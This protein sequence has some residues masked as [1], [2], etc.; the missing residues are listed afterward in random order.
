M[1]KKERVILVKGDQSKWYEQAIF[2]VNQ[3]TPQDQMPLDFVSEAEKIIH[4]HVR[5]RYDKNG[6]HVSN[7]VGI[8]YSSAMPG[9]PTTV[10][11]PALPTPQAKKKKKNKG[12]DFIVNAIMALSCIGI[13]LALMWNFF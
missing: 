13:A 5:K 1:A 3:D 7:N 11:A 12:L 2:I 6:R 8:A 4:N 9:K 10:A